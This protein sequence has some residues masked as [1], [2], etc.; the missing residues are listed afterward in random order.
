MAN[1]CAAHIA[2]GTMIS[3]DDRDN[4][5]QKRRCDAMNV[6]FAVRRRRPEVCDHGGGGLCSCCARAH[7]NEATRR[8][9][10][11][12]SFSR[13]VAATQRAPLL[14]TC[15]RRRETCYERCQLA[16]AQLRIIIVNFVNL[17]NINKYFDRRVISN[18][19]S[20]VQ[21]AECRQ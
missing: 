12:A 5:R 20:I 6:R 19:L 21:I 15:R 4:Q 7:Y 1:F 10:D 17:K 14:D 18:R 16:I 9:G 2:R 8:R 3:S 11:V 13:A